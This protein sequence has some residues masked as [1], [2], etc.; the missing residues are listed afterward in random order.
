MGRT[1]SWCVHRELPLSDVISNPLSGPYI[2]AETSAGGLA[3][4]M[5]SEVAG[6]LRTNATD[7]RAAWQDYVK[8]IIDAT[9]PNQITEGGPIIGKLRD[10][11][12]SFCIDLDVTLAVQIDNEYFQGGFGQAEYFVQ[13]ENA[14]KDAGVV[15][16]LTYNDPGEERNFING[17]VSYVL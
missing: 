11:P 17:T 5:T 2:N 16:P 13:L 4:W 7:F 6:K 14:Y 10:T 8:G 15:V 3:H 12:C 1:S 9:I